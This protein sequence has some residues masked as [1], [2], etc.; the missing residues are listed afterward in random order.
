MFGLLRACIALLCPMRLLRAQTQTL[1]LHEANIE[2][3]QIVVNGASHGVSNVNVTV[4]DLRN[5]SGEIIP[6]SNFTL[7]R[8]KYMHVT[9]SSPN[10]KG[11]NQPL[12]PG[13][14]ADALIPF[15]DPDTGKPLSGARCTAAPF[16][17]KAGINQPIWVDL[18][19]P[20]TAEPG[21]YTGSYTVTTDH[22]NSPARLL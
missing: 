12:G 6:H 17:V 9:S 10:W 18:F 4:S 7:Y 19:V 15:T 22:G 16:E 13:W 5:P 20:R 2:S 3:F 21:K 8:E 1:P 11:S 14:Y